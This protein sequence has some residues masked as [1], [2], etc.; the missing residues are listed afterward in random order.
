MDEAFGI[1]LQK[2]VPLSVA[3]IPRLRESIYDMQE[4]A[5]RVELEEMWYRRESR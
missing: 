5:Q 4:M 3:A 1:V 2:A